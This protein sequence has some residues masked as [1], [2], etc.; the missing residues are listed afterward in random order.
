MIRPLHLA[1]LLQAL[2]GGPAT[3]AGEA[4]PIS[5]VVPLREVLVVLAVLA[6][7]A[8]TVT[9]CLLAHLST[10]NYLP[11]SPSP[12]RGECVWEKGPGDEGPGEAGSSLPL[13]V[14]PSPG[15]WV[16]DGRGGQGVRASE[17]GGGTGEAGSSRP[18]LEAALAKLG[19]NL[20]S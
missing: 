3:A 8:L 10:L 15:G 1:A 5:S 20:G 4:L 9:L 14:S 13:T 19:A 12:A 18:V 16:G 7:L 17:P 2:P 6:V 11:S